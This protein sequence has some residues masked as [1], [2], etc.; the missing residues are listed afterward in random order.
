MRTTWHLLSLLHKSSVIPLNVCSTLGCKSL[1]LYPLSTWENTTIKLLLD[2][3]KDLFS[4][5]DCTNSR[6][7]IKSGK[8][9]LYHFC[10][11]FVLC[12]RPESWW[13]VHFGNYEF[14]NVPEKLN[15]LR[16]IFVFL[17]KH[18]FHTFIS[19]K[20]LCSAWYTYS[21]L[22]YNWMK[23]FNILW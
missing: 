18:N 2:L 19:N 14:I 20:M 16:K 7:F 4:K 3:E 13:E 9:A 10:V 6:V 11:I 1:I 17:F 12:A 21:I 8:F 5:I 22:N 23:V 15:S